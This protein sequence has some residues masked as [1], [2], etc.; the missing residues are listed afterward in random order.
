MTKPAETVY[1]WMKG[2]EG[3]ILEPKGGTSIL[4][5]VVVGCL[6]WDT[7]RIL[8]DKGVLYGRAL[9]EAKEKYAAKRSR[10]R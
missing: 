3:Y 2:R 9:G 4:Q 7:L 10:S 5:S 6:P 8:Y 1:D